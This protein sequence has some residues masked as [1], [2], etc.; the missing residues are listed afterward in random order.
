MVLPVFSALLVLPLLVLAH[1]TP[2][3]DGSDC[4]VKRALPSRWYHE[5]GHPVER[6]FKRQD[7]GNPTDGVSY[8]QV[9]SPAWAAGFPGARPDLNALPKEWVDALNAAVAAGKIPNIPV[10]TDT[11]GNPAYPSGVNPGGSDVCSGTAKCKGPGDIWDAPDGVLAVS[12]D[13]GPYLVSAHPGWAR[14]IYVGSRTALVLKR[15]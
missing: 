4:S 10:A 2:H 9:G 13:D 8:P 6:L 7:G 11:G 14:L 12:F 3:P 5:P 1:P 15:T